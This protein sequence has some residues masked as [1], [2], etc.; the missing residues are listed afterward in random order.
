MLLPEVFRQFVKR[1]PIC[2]MAR[3]VL[4]RLFDAERIDQIFET[5]AERG[6]TRNILFSTLVKLMS[7]V[8][9]GVRPSVH[10]AFQALDEQEATV[11]S[12]AMYNKLDRVEP[13]VSVELVRDSAAQASEV[14]D[15]LGGQLP[16][17]LP[18]YRCRILD[19]NHL[20]AT[21]HRIAELRH[22]WAAPLPGRALVVLDP[23]RMI[24]ETAILTEDGHASERSLL[25]QVLP[26]VQPR[27]VWI[28]DRNFCTLLFLWGIL[29]RRG[30]FVIRQHGQLQ[31]RLVG[32][33]RKLGRCATGVIY[34]QRIVL[35]DADTG[36]EGEEEFRRITVKLNTPTR[37]GDTEL[38]ILTNLPEAHVDAAAIAELYAGRWTIEKAFHELT[39]TLKCEIDTLGYPKAALF[40]FCL[41][42]MAYNAVAVLK[43]A[44]RV[45]HGAEV[46][47]N[48]VSA[49]YIS[50]DLL[51]THEGM[52]IAI[53]AEH[54]TIF[55]TMR[56][57]TLAKV[58]LDLGSG[59]NLARYRKH[60][61]GPKKPPPKKSR[62]KNGGHV[63]TFKLINGLG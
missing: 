25:D 36:Q 40:A 61:R 14:I 17:R 26:F 45:A 54:W 41:A 60:P 57:K 30:Y 21:E 56:L 38:H 32:K 13:C 53:P 58:L 15:A 20:A 43:A 7:Q 42:L 11:S 9:L 12:T 8:V 6:Y 46:V 10:A 18:G 4:E 29:R 48:T 31:G 59:V 23:A 39:E 63:S 5:T 16:S 19:G 44:L 24:A 50:L 55:G 37:D 51:A 2:V 62:Y 49:Y 1:R 33:K 3:G 35:V 52:M 34:E 27:D 47:E 28:A 22:T